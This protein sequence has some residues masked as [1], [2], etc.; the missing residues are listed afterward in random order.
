MNNSVHLSF[1]RFF[2]VKELQPYLFALSKKMFE[3]HLCIGV[4]ELPDYPEFWSD[5]SLTVPSFSKFSFNW[6]LIGTSENPKHPFVF[7][8]DFLYTGRSFYYETKIIEKINALSIVDVVTLSDRRNNLLNNKDFLRAFHQ[9]NLQTDWQFVASIVGYMNNLTIVTGGPGTGKTTT[10]AKILATINALEPN[11]KLA[12]AAPTGKAGTR[13]K[14]SLL[15]TLNDPKNA[16]LNL[17]SLV[18]KVEPKT[19]HSLLGSKG[20]ESTFFKHNEENPLEAD[21]IVI[22]ES[23]MIGAALFAKLLMAVENGKR[24]ILLG[25]PN[26]LASVESGSLFS[27]LCR[28][29]NENQN[30]FNFSDFELLNDLLPHTNSLRETAKIITPTSV[31]DGKVVRLTKTYRY[32][33]GSQIDLFT[34]AVTEGKAKD[35]RGILEMGSDSLRLDET[36]SD[37]LFQ[38]FVMGYKVY[39]D[40]ENITDA[41]KKLNNLRVLCSVREGEQ[42]IYAINRKIENSLKKA[43]KLEVRDGFY[44]NQPIMV[45]KNTPSIGLMNGDVGIVRKDKSGQLR[46]YFPTTK[47]HNDLTIPQGIMGINPVLINDWETVFAMT[48]HKSQGSEFDAVLVLLP[49]QTMSRLLTREL[50]YTAITRAKKH[51]IIQANLELLKVATSQQV[52]RVSGLNHRIKL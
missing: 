6:P 44:H 2:K 40:E 3:G 30:K 45:T 7:H 11:F 18:E 32:E 33:E 34:R 41:L 9:S 23:S 31:L 1:A 16:H 19:I 12:L 21:V 49:N 4:N 43:G 50:L 13:M 42:G 8:N 47:I 15:N 36:Y 24:I 28:V 17:Q 38:D 5:W 29:A 22:D 52:Q 20:Q 26:Q 10:V 27:D 14:E 46:A 48:I 51:A 35:L 37:K 39:I 25:D